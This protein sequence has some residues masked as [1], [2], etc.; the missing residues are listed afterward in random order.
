MDIKRKSPSF[1][2]PIPG[3]LFVAIVAVGAC[4]PA[5][6]PGPPA[7]DTAAPPAG[8]TGGPA[9]VDNGCGNSG[10]VASNLFGSIETRIDWSGSELSCESMLRPQDAGVRLRFVGDVAGERLSLII[11]MPTLTRGAAGAEFPSNV[12]ANVEGSGRFFSTADLDACW[13][14][15]AEQ[16]AVDTG[17][18]EVSGTLYCVSPLGEVN[19]D[20]AV[21]IPEL[22]FRT[23]ITWQAS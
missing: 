15:I 22:T 10:A 19:G 21:T 6:T 11:A 20:A 5:A 16:T 7:A 4:Q 23:L 3:W 2:P 12:T 1:N 9:S 17:L 8:S 13:A 18:Y 14:D